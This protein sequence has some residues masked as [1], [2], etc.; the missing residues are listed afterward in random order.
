MLIHRGLNIKLNKEK[1]INV[2]G[3]SHDVEFNTLS[4]TLEDGVKTLLGWL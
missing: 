4:R 3:F 1:F 2:R